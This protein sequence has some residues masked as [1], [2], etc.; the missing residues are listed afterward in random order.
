M[1]QGHQ[2]QGQARPITQREHMVETMSEG[3][4]TVRG[5]VWGLAISAPFWFALAILLLM[6]R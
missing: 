1:Q 5:V 2:E 3:H 6:L 4:V